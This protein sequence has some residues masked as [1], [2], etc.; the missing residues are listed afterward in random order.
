LGLELVKH[1]LNRLARRIVQFGLQ[2]A[3][4]ARNIETDYLGLV[5]K[6][7]CFVFDFFH[8]LRGKICQV[9]DTPNL[10]FS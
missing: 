3:L 6:E 9:A 5:H 4:I 10:N 7:F 8:T 2:H 1:P